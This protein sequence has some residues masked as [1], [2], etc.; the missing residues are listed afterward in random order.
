LG[1]QAKRKARE[2]AK[3]QRIA[4]ERHLAKK[5]RGVPPGSITK[6]STPE[7]LA[8]C[9][10]ILK[11]TWSVP[12]A[13]AQALAEGGESAPNP[14][15]GYMLVDTGASATCI[16]LDAAQELRL[17]PLRYAKSYGAGGLHELPVFGVL[18]TITF[19]DPMGGQHGVN[20]EVEAKGIP[21]LGEYFRR[22]PMES[23]GSF[24][25]RMIGLI[26]RDLLRHATFVY[27]GSIGQFDFKLDMGSFAQVI[28]GFEPGDQSRAMRGRPDEGRPE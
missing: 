17:S 1:S 13:L 2:K 18:L 23:K 10:P 19:S 11:A 7:S 4:R 20:G 16:A 25:M 14:V 6:Y 24:P 26:G 5:K 22:L 3:K 28:Q 15:V 12:P 8:V 21:E 27:K 9:G